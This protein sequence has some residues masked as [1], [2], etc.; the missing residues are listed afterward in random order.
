MFIAN[1]VP[2]GQTLSEETSA[3]ARQA[4]DV[5]D[6][7]ET[8][9]SGARND[10]TGAMAAGMA[11]MMVTAYCMNDEEFA[12]NALLLDLKEEDRTQ[13][14]CITGELGGPTQLADAMMAAQYGNPEAIA[15]AAEACGI[16]TDPLSDPAPVQKGTGQEEQPGSPPDGTPENSGNTGLNTAPVPAGA[17]ANASA[18]KPDERSMPE[19]QN[20]RS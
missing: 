19:R 4:F 9:T 16:D 5:I 3:C 14:H 17:T 11:M 13:V 18:P 10:F 8:M 7:R 15:A 1:F 2:S 6:P 20:Q 12:A